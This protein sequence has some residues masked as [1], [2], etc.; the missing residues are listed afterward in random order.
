ME[1]REDGANV[2]LSLR[3]TRVGHKFPTY[4]VPRVRM[5]LSLWRYQ[6]GQGYR[7]AFKEH[8]IE[9]KVQLVDGNWIEHSDT[10]L[11]PGEAA[12]LVL[13][14][15]SEANLAEYVILVEPD[16]FYL[17]TL[18]EPNAAEPADPLIERLRR[19]ARDRARG[20]AYILY[21]GRLNKSCNLKRSKATAF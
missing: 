5:Q 7:L 17:E 9:R 16:A 1:V 12:Y 8:I 15:Q 18:Y 21:E 4:A 20:N 19:S 13:D 14:W 2:T 10:R 11:S 3:S 6:Q